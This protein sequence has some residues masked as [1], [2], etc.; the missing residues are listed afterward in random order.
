MKQIVKAV[1]VTTILLMAGK[2][3]GFVRE[4]FIAGYFGASKATDMY[5]VA[6]IIPTLMFTAVG[7]AISSGLMPRYMEERDRNEEN[8]SEMMSVMA[9]F[10]FSASIGVALI[11]FLFVPIITR[12]IAPGFGPEETKMTGYLIR[13]M[14]PGFCFYVLSGVAKGVLQ[15]HKK[16]ASPAA[17]AIPHNVIIISF[18]VLTTGRYGIVGLTVGTLFGVVSEFLIQVPQLLKCRIRFNVSFKKYWPM[19]KGMLVKLSPI[20]IASVAVQMNLVVDRMVASRLK[21]GSV[22]ALNYANLLMYLPLSIILMSLVTVFYPYVIEAAKESKE[23]YLRWVHQGMKM[24]VFVSIPIIVVMIV[25]KETLVSLAFERGQFTVR[26]VQMTAFAFLFYSFAFVFIALRDFLM[27]ALIAVDDTKTSMVT[28]IV[29]VAVNVVLSF[30]LAAFLAQGGIALAT[31]IAMCLQTV[32]MTVF[33]HRKIGVQQ[34]FHQ[35]AGRYLLLF[36]TV[37]VAASLFV[38]AVPPLP[39]LLGLSVVTAVVFFCFFVCASILRVTEMERIKVW[40]GGK[41]WTSSL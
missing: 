33:L 7:L 25:E 5:F 37:L 23:R 40:L 35:T 9:T 21:D 8:A 38:I 13:I 6:S 22:S 29:A 16:F 4:A 12:F 14:I 28:S 1:S 11:A 27:R 26:D 36:T 3:L 17:I 10:L 20:I 2:L 19:M 39:G 32:L 30:L 31:A 24:I 15:A 41:R 18:I 34:T